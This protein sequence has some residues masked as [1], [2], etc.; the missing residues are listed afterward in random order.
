MN[1][2]LKFPLNVTTI[3]SSPS[4]AQHAKTKYI[5]TS[6]K[7]IETGFIRLPIYIYLSVWKHKIFRSLN[8]FPPFDIIKNV[9]K[10]R[11]E[12]RMQKNLIKINYYY[13]AKRSE[14]ITQ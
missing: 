5:E 2:S 4:E 12:L 6:E 7:S 1:L 8:Y 9:M 3:L 14:L 11:K 13:I 10:L